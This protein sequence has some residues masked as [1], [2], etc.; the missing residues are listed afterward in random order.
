MP[1][2]FYHV[3]PHDRLQEGQTIS[4]QEIPKTITSHVIGNNTLS[5]DLVHS[6]LSEHYEEGLSQHGLRYTGTH[7]QVDHV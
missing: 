4:L 6:K 2:S 7:P 1:E 3:D 5:E